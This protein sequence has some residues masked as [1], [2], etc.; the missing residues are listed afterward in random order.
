MMIDGVAAQRHGEPEAG[1]DDRNTQYA[2]T[3]SAQ[4]AGTGSA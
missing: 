2:G 3:A 4:Y 1:T